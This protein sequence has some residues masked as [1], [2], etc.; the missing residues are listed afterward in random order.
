MNLITEDIKYGISTT[1]EKNVEKTLYFRTK[2][3]L[4]HNSYFQ[5]ELKKCY[6][7]FQSISCLCN[8]NKKLYLTS[9]N[10]TGSAKYFLAIHKN[11]GTEHKENCLFFL[12]KENLV[13]NEGNYHSSIFEE[14]TY[15]YQPTTSEKKDTEEKESQRKNTYYNFCRDFIRDSYSYAFNKKN[16]DAK[17]RL[18]LKNP[19]EL[20]FRDSFFDNYENKENNLIKNQSIKESIPKNHTLVFGTIRENIFEQLDNPKDTYSINVEKLEKEFEINKKTNKPEFKSYKLN[21][22]KYKIDHKRLLLTQN[23]I[24]N[25]GNIIE[26]PY[27]FIGVLQKKEWKDKKTKKTITNYKMVR[28]FVHPIYSENQKISFIE[29]NY[30]RNYAR[31]LFDNNIPFIKPMSDTDFSKVH[32]RFVN[33]ETNERDKDN[34]KIW[35]RAYLKYRPDFIEFYENH[36]KI[37]EVSGYEDEQ[38]IKLMNRKIEHYQREGEKSNGLYQANEVKGK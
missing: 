28:M 9:K 37:T 34:N 27:F 15:I 25:F 17:S 36:I 26:G 29:S 2:N 10:I 38:Y 8:N 16:K 22:K 33:Y 6:G 7:K 4:K 12:S 20:D 21:N 1:P 13:D 30:E 19:S 18:T 31:Q 35:K 32:S 14:P 23:L 3:E 24:K 5:N 11:T